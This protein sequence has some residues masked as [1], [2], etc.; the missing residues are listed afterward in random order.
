VALSGAGLSLQPRPW[1][2][3]WMLL[4]AWGCTL[5]PYYL[6]LT[7]MRHLTAFAANLTVNLEPVYGV[8]LAGLFFGEHRELSPG[9]YIGVGI[10]LLSVFSHPFLVR[11]F[12]KG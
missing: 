6:T 5:L 8:I 9:F 2:W 10:I 3:L 11:W 1:D 4:L 7:A 12:G